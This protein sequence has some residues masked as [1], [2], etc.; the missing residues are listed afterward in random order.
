[1]R[2]RFCNP[3]VKHRLVLIP[4]MACVFLSA[5]VS[6]SKYDALNRKYDALNDQYQQ[7]QAQ[8]QA[9]IAADNQRIA[10]LSQQVSR[11]QGAIKFTV[12]SDLLFAP[13]SWEISDA[14]KQVMARLASQLAPYQQSKL[15]V[16]G[17]TDNAPIG[18]SLER[19]GVTSNEVLSQKR[20]ESVMQFLI[21]Q[22]VKPELISAKG[23]GD[24]QPVAPNNTPQGRAQN[25]RVEISLA[26]TGT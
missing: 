17:Y 7:S 14:G 25:R 5:C 19:Q 6:A 8:A 12:N 18:R 16:N 23:W 15:V 1:M 20:A 21:S 26:G 24:A 10:S 13:G 22:G 2:C 3:L 11:L 9:Q 4:I